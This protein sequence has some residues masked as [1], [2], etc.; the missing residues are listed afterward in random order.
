MHFEIATRLVHIQP[1]IADSVKEEK[2]IYLLRRGLKWSDLRWSGP[3][4]E[5]P[6]SYPSFSLNYKNRATCTWLHTA[7]AVQEE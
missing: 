5:R 3:F 7:E 2:K 6:S 1:L 4:L